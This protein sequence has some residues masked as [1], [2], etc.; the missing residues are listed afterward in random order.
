M[1]EDSE[2]VG[3]PIMARDII[4]VNTVNLL[5]LSELQTSKNHSATKELNAKVIEENI[6]IVIVYCPINNNNIVI[7]SSGLSNSESSPQLSVLE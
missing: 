3:S 7:W 6:S 2:C 5:E 4:H 1:N